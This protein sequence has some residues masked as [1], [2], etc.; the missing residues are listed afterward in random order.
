MPHDLDAE[1]RRI[2]HGAN[3]NGRVTTIYSEPAYSQRQALLISAGTLP[4]DTVEVAGV[5]NGER[6]SVTVTA[7]ER[8][9]DIQQP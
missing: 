9:D 1:S 2:I 8:P 7:A 5:R 3:R 6:F 4:G